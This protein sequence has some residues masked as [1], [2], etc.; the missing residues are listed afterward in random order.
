MELGQSFSVECMHLVAFLKESNIETLQKMKK[1][2]H[3]CRLLK[4]L[5]LCNVESIFPNTEVAL[6][7][8][9]SI[10]VTNYATDRSFSVING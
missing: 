10:A 9:Q 1:Q 7:N 6:Q 2:F 3:P 4:F 8:I 5:K